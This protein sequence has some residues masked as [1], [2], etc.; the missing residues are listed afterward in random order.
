MSNFSAQAFVQAKRLCILGI[1]ESP[2]GPIP[3]SHAEN[4]DSEDG[5]VNVSGELPGPVAEAIDQSEKRI[6]ADVGQEQVR[7]AAE[8]LVDRT[9][10][11]DQNAAAMMIMVK[12]NAAK[13]NPRAVMTMRYMLKYAK[14]GKQ[15]VNINGDD[16]PRKNAMSARVIKVLQNELGP[17]AT[18]VQYRSAVLTMLPSLSMLEGS[19]TLSNGPDLDKDRIDS[20]LEPLN[21]QDKHNFMSG[22]KNWRN[23]GIN[24]PDVNYRL[25]RIF[26]LARTIQLVRL[27][28]TPIGSLSKAAGLELD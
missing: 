13:G 6:M 3:F 20:V 12:K 23:T 26:G 2:W 1:F 18:T 22:F 17:E 19:V 15:Q 8:D 10:D 14:R 27:P 16:E 7:L 25:G 4:C 28:Q 21:D 24:N 11:G 5:P 9:N